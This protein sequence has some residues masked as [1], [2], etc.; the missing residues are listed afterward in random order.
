MQSHISFILIYSKQYLLGSCIFPKALGCH[1]KKKSVL[2]LMV[3][4]LF[5]LQ[6]P[7]NRHL[8]D[9]NDKFKILYVKVSASPAE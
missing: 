2:R 4:V 3:L 8:D 5:T 1:L 9:T 7:N 6:S